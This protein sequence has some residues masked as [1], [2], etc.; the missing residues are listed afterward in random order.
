MDTARGRREEGHQRMMASRG[1]GRRP[2][3][4]SAWRSG[5]GAQAQIYKNTQQWKHMARSGCLPFPLT[6]K[7]TNVALRVSSPH[8]PNCS[9]YL[10]LFGCFYHYFAM[11]LL[12]E[13][14]APGFVLR[15]MYSRA[16]RFYRHAFLCL[17]FSRSLIFKSSSN[18]AFPKW[19]R[20]EKKK[21]FLFALYSADVCT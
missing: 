18:F 3:V 13:E 9:F 1:G 19:R 4:G 5:G 15:G 7:V 8:P 14:P 17:F 10:R 2:R 21:S 11:N 20:G 6:N 12:P 16:D